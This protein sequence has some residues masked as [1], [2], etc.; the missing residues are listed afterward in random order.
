MLNDDLK[1]IIKSHQD[2]PINGILFRDIL[3]VLSKPDIF[4]SLIDE[5]A[6]TEI[7]K[8]SEAIL[9]ID[10]RGFIFG[11]GIALKLSKPLVVARKP[12]KLPGEII[13]DSYELEYGKNSLS[14]QKD[15][16]EKF[17]SFAIV[18]DLL[19]TGGTVESVSRLLF[20]NQKSITG[21]AIVVELSD[22]NG[23]SKFNF[24]VYSQIKY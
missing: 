21:L 4:S 24:P 6:D 11:S 2:F 20:S 5:M 9:A 22:L 1:R 8:S 7:C 17:N 13:T 15:I 3:P 23:K 12:G 18:D 19:A 16:L 10:A 14:I